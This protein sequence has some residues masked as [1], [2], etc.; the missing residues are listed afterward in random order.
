MSNR[1]RGG[2]AKAL[3]PDALIGLP[4][5][6]GPSYRRNRFRETL[7]RL[8]QLEIDTVRRLV[9]QM[10]ALIADL[11]R[12]ANALESHIQAEQVRTGIHDPAHFAYSTYAKATIVRQDNLKQSISRLKYQLAA[13]KAGLAEAPEK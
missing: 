11:D 2:L 8:K 4:Q 1:H 3:R 5:R 9:A 12:T 13:A 10:E 6:S 7:I